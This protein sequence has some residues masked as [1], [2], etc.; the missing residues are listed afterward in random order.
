MYTFIINDNECKDNFLQNESAIKTWF[1][2]CDWSR[3]TL[4]FTSGF[5]SY[6]IGGCTIELW[7]ANQNVHG[8]STHSVR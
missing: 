8:F 3:Q 5:K 6:L 2:F 1:N 4:S 7:K